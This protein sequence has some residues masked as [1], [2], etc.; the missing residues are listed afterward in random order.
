M[1]SDHADLTERVVRRYVEAV[2]R[3][4]GPA[5]MWERLHE[6][7]DYTKQNIPEEYHMLWEQVK[8]QFKGDPH[9]RYEH[10]MEWV[11]ENP[12]ANLHVQMEAAEKA[13]REWAR[14]ERMEALCQKRCP[15]CY[16]RPSE[17]DLEDVPF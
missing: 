13:Q 8:R 1:M 3:P 17:Y 16:N 15:S 12:D 9:S 2:Y 4:R 5:K 7:D 11:E 6:N 14:K 10:F